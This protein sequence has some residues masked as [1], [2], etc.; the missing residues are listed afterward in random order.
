MGIKV[1]RQDIPDEPGFTQQ[2]S[3]EDAIGNMVTGFVLQGKH[4]VT[5]T[6]FSAEQRGVF[7]T[8]NLSPSLK[9]VWVVEEA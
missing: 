1:Y 5:V 3:L 4:E 8:V 9:I 7:I 6:P 2:I